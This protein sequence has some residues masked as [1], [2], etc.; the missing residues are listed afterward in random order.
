LFSSV[1][2][3]L[4]IMFQWINH[5]LPFESTQI[6]KIIIMKNNYVQINIYMGSVNNLLLKQCFLVPCVCV[7]VCVRAH[8][9]ERERERER[10]R[11]CMGLMRGGRH[12]SC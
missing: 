7:C 8:V 6:N 4:F 9:R 2:I 11:A 3:Y 1:W 12:L 5:F 10:T